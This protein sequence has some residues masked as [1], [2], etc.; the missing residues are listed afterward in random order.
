MKAYEILNYFKYQI[1]IKFSEKIEIEDKEIYIVFKSSTTLVPTDSTKD[2]SIIKKISSKIKKTE[3]LKYSTSYIETE[4]I[5]YI[6]KFENEK[7]YHLKPI[8][9][10]DIQNKEYVDKNKK[11][12]LKKFLKEEISKENQIIK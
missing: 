5:G 10:K 11:E 7:E 9:E 3:N 2:K 4:P 8:N 6:V 12:I 1:E